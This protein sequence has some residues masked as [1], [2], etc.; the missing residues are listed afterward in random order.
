MNKKELNFKNEE[1]LEPV[2][3]VINEANE[4]LMDKEKIITDSSI[5]DVMAGALGAGVGGVTSFA[6]L[7]FGGSV[8]GLSAAGITSGLAAAGA[9]VGG[10]M[11]AGIAVLAAPAVILGGA[12]LKITAD[13]KRKQ[14]KNKKEELYTIAIRKQTII[15]E[16]LKNNLENSQERIKALTALNILL[17][18]AI[19]SLG[20][21]LGKQSQNLI[22]LI[23][24]KYIQKNN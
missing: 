11:A 5:S 2:V 23:R 15:L 24:K 18:S 12:A 14:L 19:K 22:C 17:Q 7:Y 8:V 1:S 13:K 10:G 20:E 3:K 9:V 4:F 6:A 16:E 21:D